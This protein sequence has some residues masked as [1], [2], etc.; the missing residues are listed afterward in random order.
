MVARVF[1]EG[2]TPRV[3]L[4]L[5]NLRLQHRFAWHRIELAV[6]CAIWYCALRLLIVKLPVCVTCFVHR[7]YMQPKGRHCRVYEAERG[8][9]LKACCL[10]C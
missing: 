2:K 7:L 1:G 5:I 10:S 9:P 4:V 6:V 8:A 3:Q